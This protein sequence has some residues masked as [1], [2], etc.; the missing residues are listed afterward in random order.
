MVGISILGNMD[1]LWFHQIIL[2]QESTSQVVTKTL[3]HQNKLLSPS[4]SIC[5]SSFPEAKVSKTVSPLQENV[6]LENS[7]MDDSSKEDS[8]IK[9]IKRPRTLSVGTSR[10]RSPFSPSTQSL[11]D[12]ELE[13]VK[14]FMDLAFIFNREHLNRRIMRVILGL[15]R[16]EFHKNNDT[17]IEQP[18]E[19][20]AEDDTKQK[21]EEGGVTRL[22]LSETWLIKRPSS[23][24][25]NLKFPREL[26]TFDMKKYLRFW[27]R[28][29]A[30]E[31][32]QES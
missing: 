29:I 27:A 6:S 1:H 32:Q 8:V 23:P 18:K 26:A 11:R 21:E 16:F 19:D 20:D 17:N 28:T 5:V 3:E 4:P 10:S 25:L 14:G 22:Y 30:L 7:S 2:F 9:E 24:L 15:Q 12:L 31:I 13:E